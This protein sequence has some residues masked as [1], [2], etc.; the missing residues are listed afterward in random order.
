MIGLRLYKL[1]PT[2]EVWRVSDGARVIINKSDF[3]SLLYVKEKPGIKQESPKRGRK[4]KVSNA[5]N[6]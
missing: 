5:N 6:R 1:I 3:D 4:P 2:I